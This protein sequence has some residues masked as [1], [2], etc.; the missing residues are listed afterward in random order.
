M[1]DFATRYIVDENINESMFDHVDILDRCSTAINEGIIDMNI[2]DMMANHK[3]SLTYNIIDIIKDN[4]IKLLQMILEMVNNFILNTSKLVEKYK[5]KIIERVEKLKD[6]FII[7][8]YEYPKY[9]S[10]DYPVIIHPS[11]H[12]KDDVDN[13]VNILISKTDPKYKNNDI[14]SGEIELAVDRMIVDFGYKVTGSYISAESNS[15]IKS[16]VRSIVSQ[17]IVGRPIRINASK[18]SIREYLNDIIY[19]GDIRA[20]IKKTKE[21]IIKEYNSLKA[22]YKK[23]GKFIE[24]PKNNDILYTKYPDLMDIIHNTPDVVSFANQQLDRLLDSYIVI[25]TE[26]FN[27]K[28]KLLQE[29]VENNKK[30]ISELLI[31]T[32]VFSSL[33]SK[34]SATVITPTVRSMKNVTI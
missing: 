22:S 12:I 20:D 10:P 6:P 25:Y 16:S 1:Y 31:K 5:D 14:Y 18:Q 23:Y 19:F 21:A 27:T 15:A 8:T 7:D 4:L 28:L 17:T 24:S 13:L 3:S 33:N 9:K 29:R 32:A 34:P 26:A 2:I 11:D 30:I